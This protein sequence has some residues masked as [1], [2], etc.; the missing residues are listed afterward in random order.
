MLS[1]IHQPNATFPGFEA[2][3]SH[4]WKLLC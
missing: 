2:W 4:S 3:E 1:P